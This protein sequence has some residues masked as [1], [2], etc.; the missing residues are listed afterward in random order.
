MSVCIGLASITGAIVTATVGT[1][2]ADSLKPY[3]GFNYSPMEQTQFELEEPMGSFGIEYDV[4]K[5]VRLF[6]E[7]IST[8]MDCND[9]PGINHA[10]VKLLAPINDFTLYS[11]ISINHSG[12]DRRDK[13]NGPLGSIGIEYGSD[14][15]V[16]VEY[17]TALENIDE[18][19][20]AIGV[21]VFFK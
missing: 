5:H 4:H 2:S 11:G 8:P 14:V 15:K 12:F 6:A 13:F 10:G 7:H 1:V 9:N 21:K 16:F 19:R 3:I 17:L 20:A 18:G